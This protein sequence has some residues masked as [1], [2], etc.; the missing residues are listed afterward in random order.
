[1][2]K[3]II[4]SVLIITLLFTII[5]MPKF[6]AQTE[7]STAETEDTQPPIISCNIKTKTLLPGET[8]S[9]ESLGIRAQDASKIE[10]LAF[11]K[12]T[13]DSFYT[14]LP[15]E[16]MTDMRAAYKKGISF[17]GEE[18]VFSYGGIYTL[19]IEA[20]DVYQNRSE[21]TITIKVEEPP[22]LEIPS[23]FY[24]VKG[25]DIPFGEHIYAWDF[26]DES[27]SAADLDIDSGAV[28][29]SKPGS[30]P[31]SFTGKDSYGLSQTKTAMVHVCAKE[32]LQTMINTHEIQLGEQV[33]VGAYNIY[34][35]GYFD[36]IDI[37]T[38]RNAFLPATVRIEN[39]RNSLSGNG[40]I[41]K[42]DDK[43]LTICTTA[44]LTNNCINPN[45][46]FADGTSRI[47][48][49]V[50][51]DENTHVAFISIPIDGASETTSL[52]REYT[53]N[54]RTVHIDE[55]YWKTH[56]ETSPKLFSASNTT[57][58]AVFD[59]T[60]RLFGMNYNTSPSETIDHYIPL[61]DILKQYELAF[62]EKLQY[63]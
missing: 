28:N 42:V 37:E 24:T 11:T 46:I 32:E 49:V 22:I 21:I 13:S 36:N 59:E 38:L 27:F 7:H 14:G 29:F 55:A 4:L 10:S 1:M 17:F 35:M 25:Q 18:L 30:Y 26:L 50:R 19:T 23:D 3:K 47:G 16:E 12:I 63:Q 52:S 8:I 6:T 41:V 43:M 57:G 33:I 61:S 15:E 48:S 2:K 31:I 20:C 56:K 60:G 62:M 40:L 39:P 5:L 34:D 58:A 51:L 9:I 53:K 54:L 45:V 44:D